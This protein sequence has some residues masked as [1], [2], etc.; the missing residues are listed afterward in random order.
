VPTGVA[1]RD[2]RQQLFDAA[3]RILLRDGSGALTSRAVT[4]E[5]GCAKGVLHR[6][7]AGFEEFLAEFV[8]DRM[9]RMDSQ[10]AALRDSAGTGTVAGNLTEALTA[11]YG[12]VAVAIVGLVAAR[13][14]LRARLSRD[15]PAGIPVVTEAMTMVAGYLE[16]ERDLGRIASGADIGMLAPTV[17]GAVHMQYT[18]AEGTPPDAATVGRIVTTVITGSLPAPGRQA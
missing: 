6:H 5:A 3:E 13:E 11:L 16:S 9:G 15:W 18:R 12:S 1:L 8:L 10:A 2:A 17:V 14:S 4:T 7:F